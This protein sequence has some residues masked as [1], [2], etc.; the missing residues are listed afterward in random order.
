MVK[1]VFCCLLICSAAAV[2]AQKFFTRNGQA[3]F[4]SRTEFEDIAAENKQVMATL[5][6]GK[7]TVSVAMLMKGFLFRKELMQEHFNENYIES[8]RFPK[9]SFEGIFAAPADL[10]TGLKANLLVKG[11]LSLHGV[12]LPVELP[13]TLQLI[14]NQLIAKADF[15]LLP[16]DYKIKIPALVRDKISKKIAVQLQFELKQL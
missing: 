9:A 6:L 13:V 5:D 16:E 2:N 11:Q 7:Q 10:M 12:T 14:N 15:L 8:D 3:R 4:F 1:F